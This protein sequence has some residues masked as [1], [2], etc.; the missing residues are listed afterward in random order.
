[1]RTITYNDEAG[2]GVIISWEP[3]GSQDNNFSRT[4]ENK[5]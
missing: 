1:M 4:L 3:D 2:A 5:N